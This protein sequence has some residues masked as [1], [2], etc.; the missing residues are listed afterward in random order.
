MQQGL[1][2]TGNDPVRWARCLS[3][4][5][6]HLTILCP[7]SVAFAYEEVSGRHVPRLDFSFATHIVS[8]MPDSGRLSA[9]LM[10]DCFTQMLPDDAFTRGRADGVPRQPSFGDTCSAEF[11]AQLLDFRMLLLPI[12]A[13]ASPRDG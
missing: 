12:C 5:V 2:D 6:R 1:H 10:S 13:T 9:E 11:M 3:E 7:R 4:I 8:C